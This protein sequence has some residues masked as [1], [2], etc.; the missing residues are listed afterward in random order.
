LRIEFQPAQTNGAERVK[1]F[2]ERPVA[3]HRRQPEN[4]SKI[5]TLTPGRN[6][7][8]AHECTDFDLIR[9]HKAW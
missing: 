9:G 5:S 1:R 6:S 3:L 2:S 7:T 8:D 4:I